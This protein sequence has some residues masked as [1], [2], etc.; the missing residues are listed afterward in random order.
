MRAVRTRLDQLQEHQ[1][2]AFELIRI[3]LGI[4]L[5]VRGLL[6]IWHS[7]RLL[8]IM[9]RPGHDWFSSAALAHYIV[10]AHLIGGCLLALGFLTRLAALIQIPVLLGAVFLVHWKEGLLATSQSLELS[11]LVL[12]LLVLFCFFGA[13]PHSVDHYLATH[14]EVE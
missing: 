8:D 12:F 7:S 3:Y 1:Y 13:G 5:A 2:L 11:A 6:L 10:G 4:A 9:G 14:Q